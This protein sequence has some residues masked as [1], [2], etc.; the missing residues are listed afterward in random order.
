MTQR[1]EDLALLY[2]VLDEENGPDLNA[3]T[4]SAFQDILERMTTLKNK[5]LA[6]TIWQQQEMT[7]AQRA[8]V[9]KE[10][11]FPHRKKS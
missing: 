1:D 8:Q 11:G 5:A 6:A 3:G 7:T 9:R 10:L 2:G 4:R